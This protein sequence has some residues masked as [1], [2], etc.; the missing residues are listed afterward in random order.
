MQSESSEEFLSSV[1]IARSPSRTSIR[2]RTTRRE[3]GEIDRFESATNPLLFFHSRELFRSETSIPSRANE[4]RKYRGVS[5]SLFF[6]FSFNL[7]GVA[8]SHRWKRRFGNSYL[9]GSRTREREK[10][11]SH[12]PNSP[13]KFYPAPSC[14]T[15][16]LSIPSFLL[17][18]FINFSF[19]TPSSPPSLSRNFLIISRGENAPLLPVPFHSSLL[20]F[21]RRRRKERFADRHLDTVFFIFLAFISFSSPPSR[22]PPAKFPRCGVPH[23]LRRIP[24]PRFFVFALD[25]I[26][27]RIS[28]LLRRCGTFPFCLFVSEIFTVTN[29]ASTGNNLFLCLPAGGPLCLPAIFS[30]FTILRGSSIRGKREREKKR[31]RKETEKEEE[32]ETRVAGN[33]I[34]RKDWNRFGKHESIPG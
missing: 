15:P 7:E 26:G 6:S 24:A 22:F 27:K 29:F 23:L 20:S 3:I 19:P 25:C 14:F 13:D 1:V 32:K 17:S 18:F 28:F 34:W 8:G 10:T 11:N 33:N 4:I 12:R 30:N 2:T 16:L 31:K 9:L 21:P 5:L